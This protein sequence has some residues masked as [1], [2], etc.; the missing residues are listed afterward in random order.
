MTSR[1]T[2]RKANKTYTICDLV[3]DGFTLSVTHLNPFMST[4]GHFHPYEEAYYFVDGNK[5]FMEF[6]RIFYPAKGF[7]L[8]PTNEFH[9]VS[10]LSANILTFVCAWKSSTRQWFRVDKIDIAH[11]D[12][13]RSI[14]AVFNGDF[15]AHQVKLLK[16][17][18]QSVFGNHYHDY[19]EMF[20]ILEGSATYTLEKVATKE[21]QSIVLNQGD[22]LVIEPC[23][24][25]RAEMAEGTITLEATEKPYISADKNDVRYEIQRRL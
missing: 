5:G 1:V 22:R 7:I 24:A 2:V 16:V 3:S 6:G 10:N 11:E 21:Q 14:T 19:R 4:V 23:I 13:R 12:E 20:Y 25:H 18:G 17:K 9:Y 8:V 15:I